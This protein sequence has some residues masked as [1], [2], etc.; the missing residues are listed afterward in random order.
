MG[1]LRVPMLMLVPGES[2]AWN[3]QAKGVTLGRA[4]LAVDDH[5]VHS[6][7]E[8]SGLAAAFSKV[9][10]ELVT[11]LGT[12]GPRSATDELE[13]DGEIMRVDEQFAGP[14]V[15]VDHRH[16][17]IVPGGNFGHTLHSALGLIRAWAQPDAPPGYLFV[18][19]AGGVYRLDVARPFVEALRGEPALRVELRIKIDETDTVAVSMW[20]RD[21][22]R[23]PLRFEVAMGD[24][25]AT[26]DLIDTDL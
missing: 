5:E 12:G 15:I 23:V 1:P 4:V 24:I 18:V 6:R 16:V 3:V 2:M 21:R 10:H 26:A 25:H 11:E 8:T 7:F 22:D 17:A 14:R 19:H 13:I 9:R 20:L